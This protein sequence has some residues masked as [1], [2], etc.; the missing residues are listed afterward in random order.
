M[1]FPRAEF[2]RLALRLARKGAGRTSPNPAVGAVLVR[3]GEVVGEGFHRAAG[4]PHA[5]AMA[6]QDAGEAARGAD[7]YVTLEP[8][9]HAGRTGPCTRAI[10]AAG[11]RRVAAAMQD[12]NPLV[13]GKG[14]RALRR[15][16]IPVVRGM[17][18][19]EARSLNRS[20]CRWVVSGRPF[21]TLKLAISL[22]G[23]VASASGE[24]RWIS[25]EPARKIV[26][27]MRSET[28]AVLVGG[29]TYR[30]DAPQ[31]TARIRGGRNPGRVI[32][33]SRIAGLARNGRFL[34]AGGRVIVAAPRGVSR[35]EADRLRFLGIRV[36]LL[37]TRKGR[38]EASVF[39]DALGREGITS[40][41]AEGGGKTAGW[42]VEAG[43]VDRYVFFLA[44][45]LLGEGVRS[46]A[47]FAAGRMKEGRRLLITSVKRAGS[48]IMVVAEPASAV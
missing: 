26:H 37:P 34:K 16:G 4:L 41:L 48:D 17:M 28:D 7:L 38:I 42:L 15:A 43:A 10:I 47:G 6:L 9:A 13:A 35:E 40:L 12:P 31:L 23:Q 39:L 14:F 1:R 8:C 44:P 2:M 19:E 33:T 3:R 11:V 27:R 30:Q 45:L 36:L 46:I 24:S 32:L 21:V 20:Y 22:D 25:G 29:E 18:E 5:E